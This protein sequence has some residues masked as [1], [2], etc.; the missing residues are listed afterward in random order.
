[1]LKSIFFAACM[2]PVTMFASIVGTYEVNGFDPE[3]NAEY[4]GQVIIEKRHGKHDVYV[5]TWTFSDGSTDTASGV[6]KGD[7]VS[8]VF[9]ET[10]SSVYG[11]QLYKIEDHEKILKG[12]W[13]RFGA[14]KKG[15]EKIHKIHE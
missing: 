2:L 10:T 9:N 8:F 12:P 6:L 11:T 4:T 14:V 3:T 5:A 7:F 13:V 1:M 15:F